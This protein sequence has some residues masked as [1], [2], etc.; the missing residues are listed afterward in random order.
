MTP[1][2]GIQ[3]P[4]LYDTIIRFA[5]TFKYTVVPVAIITYCFG[6]YW[7]VLSVVTLVPVA[8]ETYAAHIQG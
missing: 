3:H 8:Y 7:W 2:P 1:L 4:K 6:W 5:K